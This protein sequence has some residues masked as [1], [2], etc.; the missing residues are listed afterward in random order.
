[1]VLMMRTDCFGMVR[2]PLLLI[3]TNTIAV[4]NNHTAFHGS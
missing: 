4:G 1:M 3:Q 2:V